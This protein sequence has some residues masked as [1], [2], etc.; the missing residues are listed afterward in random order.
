M[1]SVK[2]LSDLNYIFRI[3]SQADVYDM[4]IWA[5]ID[6]AVMDPHG[7]DLCISNAS[8]DLLHTAANVFAFAA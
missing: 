5:Y 3:L 4:T 8:K 6:K 7:I 1:A 2:L